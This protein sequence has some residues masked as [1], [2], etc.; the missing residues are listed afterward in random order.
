MKCRHRLLGSQDG[1]ICVRPAVLS[2]MITSMSAGAAAAFI[3]YFTQDDKEQ[4]IRSF[5]VRRT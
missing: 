5:K 3:S 1:L 2:F 4:P